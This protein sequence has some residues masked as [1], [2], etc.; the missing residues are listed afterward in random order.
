MRDL[1]SATI[2][3]GELVISSAGTA[4][5]SGDQASPQAVEA[6]ARRGL[7]LNGHKARPLEEDLLRQ[8]DLLLTMTRG[9]KEYLI[10][11]YPW[12]AAKTFTL[13]EFTSGAGNDIA[14][15]ADSP[16]GKRSD[17]DREGLDVS[18]P[19]GDSLERYLATAQEIEEHLRRLLSRWTRKG[20]T[21]TVELP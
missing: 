19:Y 12:V 18:D 6:M 17:P 11:K 1:A 14:A 16:G 7:D 21:R 8:A 5:F 10:G 4:A 20:F 2:P 9:Q 15:S 3:E 13:K